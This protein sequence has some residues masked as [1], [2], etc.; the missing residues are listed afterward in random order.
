M[1]RTNAMPGLF[2]SLL[3]TVLLAIPTA[4]ALAQDPVATELM[5]LEDSWGAMDVH[6]DGTGI[7]KL[8]A[9][10]Y[11]FTRANGQVVDKAAF[12]KMENEDKTVVISGKNTEYK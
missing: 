11:V 3:A 7:G 6:H 12:I 5:R 2:F 9:T 4:P 10:D 8:L 1:S